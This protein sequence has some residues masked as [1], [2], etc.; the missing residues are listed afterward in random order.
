MPCLCR[1]AGI[2]LEAG[3]T[4]SLTSSP[5]HEG[6]EYHN[7]PLS[8]T[9]AMEWENSMPIHTFPHPSPCQGA[10]KCSNCPRAPVLQSTV[11]VWPHL[12]QHGSGRVP[13]LSLPARAS[14]LCGERDSSPHQCLCLLGASQLS[15]IPPANAP[16]QQR[17]PPHI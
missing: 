7:H 13:H 14:G 17:N 3:G 15:P 16:G 4:D 8:Q 2:R 5:G 6:G 1:C 12:S 9:L 11:A 10:G